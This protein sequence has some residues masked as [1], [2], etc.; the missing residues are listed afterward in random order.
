MVEKKIKEL[1]KE[2]F[3]IYGDYASMLEPQG[4]KFGTAPVEF[5]RDML[6]MSLGNSNCVSFSLCR[7]EKRP[8][9]IEASE[10][11]NFAGEM[12]IPLDGDILMHVGPAV[13]T[14]EVPA[15]Q[16]E[17]F[18]VPKGTAVCIRPG[19]WHQAAFA[20]GCDRVHILVALP[21]RTYKTDC[22]LFPLA[23][24]KQIRIIDQ[25]E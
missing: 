20:Y 13:D 8:F 23:P 11:H 15:E 24:E 22:H 7:L 3:K 5:F 18:R 6:Q 10:Y 14:D 4:V 12:I 21:E 25:A 2:S 1:T 19:V 17:I 16:I 9:V